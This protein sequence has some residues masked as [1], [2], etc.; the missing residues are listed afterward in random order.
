MLFG[1]IFVKRGAKMDWISL[2]TVKTGNKDGR[3]YTIDIA[4]TKDYSYQD[5]IQKLIGFT[6]DIEKRRLHLFHQIRVG[7]YVTLNEEGYGSNS[8]IHH[9]QVQTI[10]THPKIMSMYLKVV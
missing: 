6:V 10:N 5:A 8:I 3:N 7:D 2:D 1:I 9:L 4:Y